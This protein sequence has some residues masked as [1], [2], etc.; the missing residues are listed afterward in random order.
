MPYGVRDT[1]GESRAHII[2]PCFNSHCGVSSTDSFGSSTIFS[3]L[4]V[5]ASHR[6]TEKN[7]KEETV[8]TCNMPVQGQNVMTWTM[9][10]ITC[11]NTTG[12]PL[13]RSACSDVSLLCV[14]SRQSSS[15]V[16]SQRM[17]A[18]ELCISRHPYRLSLKVLFTEDIVLMIYQLR[19]KVS[20]SLIKASYRASRQEQ[21]LWII[22]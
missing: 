9:E 18:T 22:K 15:G 16:N 20:R 17:A 6:K 8:N 5:S 14:H 7:R 4:P 1:G 21:L 11:L 19:G 3:Y 12:N 2:Q 13:K 10:D